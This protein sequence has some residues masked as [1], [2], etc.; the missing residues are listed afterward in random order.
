M[1]LTL[2]AIIALSSIGLIISV[3]LYIAAQ[4]FMIVE[5]PRI[6]D[7]EAALQDANCGSWV[8]PVV[9]ILRRLVL[10]VRIL[11]RFCVQ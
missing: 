11:V 8:M 9:R 5:D 3:V 6:N 2:I 10:E 4:K 7:I 1:S